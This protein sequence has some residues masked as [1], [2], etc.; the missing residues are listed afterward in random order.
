MTVPL[1]L[2]VDVGSAE[3]KIA[4]DGQA[5]APVPIPA[6]R[7][8]HA[9]ALEALSA[10]QLQ[11]PLSGI[12]IASP[13]AWLSVADAGSQELLR[14]AWEDRIGIQGITWAGQLTSVAALVS[15]QR[16]PGRYLVCDIGASGVRVGMIAVSGTTVSV[17]SV[18]GAGGGW[19]QFDQAV[20]RIAGDVLPE[21]WHE[22]A[23]GQD[24][25]LGLVVADAAASPDHLGA[26]A[27]RITLHDSVCDLT[28]GQ[29]L[30]C[31]A[32]TQAS[33]LEHCSQVMGGGPPDTAVLTGGFGWFPLA[34]SVIA[35]V[36][37]SEP[38]MT[39]QDTAARGALLFARK[40]I[41]LAPEGK[42]RVEVPA[43]R[44]RDG[45]LEPVSV[46]IPWTRPFASPPDGNL[47]LT[48][49]DLHLRVADQPCRAR[50][51]GLRPGPY[52]IG[53]RAS[54]AGTSFVVARPESGDEVYAAAIDALDSS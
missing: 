44:I 40:E 14:E 30:D 17:E 42:E 18:S 10:A 43:H 41:R 20:R 38:L 8:M 6:P 47:M 50:L 52:R 32:A 9:A 5:Q 2:A 16:G 28:A 3:I 24:E 36:A 34:T 48:S 46:E 13:E 51:A 45:I 53:V 54:W 15:R 39:G 33:L 19:L 29:V 23:A 12:C 22:Q 11:R 7:D 27:L 26:R 35:S 1:Y 21:A 49:Q 31:F 4:V 25:R 37:G